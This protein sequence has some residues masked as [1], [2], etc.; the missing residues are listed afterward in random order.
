[1]I[2]PPKHF[3]R[4][5]SSLKAIRANHQRIRRRGC[6]SSME[7]TCRPRC[8]HS[9]CGSLA[10]ACSELVAFQKSASQEL[11]KQSALSSCLAER[12]QGLSFHHSIYRSVWVQ[13]VFWDCST[14]HQLP[15]QTFCNI[16]RTQMHLQRMRAANSH[17]CNLRARDL[18]SMI[19]MLRQIPLE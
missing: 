11:V 2:S 16:A 13:H 10:G 4:S 5:T 19:A 8:R 9:S 17:A 6:L 3:C 12:K 14:S 18:L 1:M 15:Q 7:Q